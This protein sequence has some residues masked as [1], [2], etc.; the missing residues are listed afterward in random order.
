M[1]RRSKQ[2]VIEELPEDDS[3]FAEEKKPEPRK[4]LHKSEVDLT[5]YLLDWFSALERV[6]YDYYGGRGK[7]SNSKVVQVLS[8]AAN[9]RERKPLMSPP[10]WEA[11]AYRQ[12]RF[13]QGAVWG[14]GIASYSQLV[15]IDDEIERWKNQPEPEVEPEEP[16]SELPV[17]TVPAGKKRGPKRRSGVEEKVE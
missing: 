9:V 12:L 11:F 5:E 15:A 4:R 3:E 7:V 10:R 8:V 17:E 14:F 13:C 6:V 16:A 1:A 2:P